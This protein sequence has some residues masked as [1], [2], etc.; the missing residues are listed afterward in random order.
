MNARA[1]TRAP[2][3]RKTPSARPTLLV[4]L[5]LHGCADAVVDRAIWLGCMMNARLT[6]VTVVP[7]P[8][9]GGEAGGET[10]VDERAPRDEA[11]LDEQA[12][13]ILQ[14]LTARILAAGLPAPKILARHGRPA[15]VILALAEEES[16]SLLVMGT[17]AR[18]GV[19]RAMFGSVAEAV[20]R[21]AP[22]PVFIDPAGRGL[23]EA[24]SDDALQA[25]AETMG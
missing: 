1:P 22:C 16:P 10:P 13:D 19:K 12:R 21:S 8:P 7:R 5:D 17:H 2:N 6:L 3:P 15:P 20:L 23:L 25:D 11:Q 9:P 24:P 18:S 14:R 4:P